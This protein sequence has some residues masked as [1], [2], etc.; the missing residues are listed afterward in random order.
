MKTR[1]E[2]IEDLKVGLQNALPS[3]IAACA[4]IL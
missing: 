3:D 4:G 2:K 1:M